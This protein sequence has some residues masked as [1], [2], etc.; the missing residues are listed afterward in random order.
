MSTKCRSRLALLCLLCLAGLPGGALRAD[1]PP[2]QV[3]FT[4]NM[5]E[6]V[7]ELR[8]DRAPLTTANFLR[9]VREGFYTNTLIQRVVPN[10]VIQGGGF[11]AT[12]QKVKPTHENVVNESG[13]GLQNKR[14]AL[15]MAR[16]EA[17]HS[18]N[19]QFFVNLVDNPDLDPVPTRWGYA[20]FGKVVQGMDV[21]DRIGS[22]PTGSVGVFKADSPL[23]PVIIE[24]AEILGAG[25][26]PAA[27][28]ETVNP[29]QPDNIL[30]PK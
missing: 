12:T 27:P 20:V 1:E 8:A 3:R 19:A 29:P 24:K 2:T 14:G 17:P 9:Y 5:G 18:S 23:K 7:V 26:A 21:I 13:N 15:G 4:T 11:D 28:S 16:G 22:T 25:A 30:S 6:F 10:F